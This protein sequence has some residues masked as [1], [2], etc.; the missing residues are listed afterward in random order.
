MT[1]TM[2]QKNYVKPELRKQL[3]FPKMLNDSTTPIKDIEDA[4]KIRNEEPGVRCSFNSFMTDTGHKAAL[5][6][7]EKRKKTKSKT[8]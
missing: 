1:K 7:L 3:V 2:T 4:V 5:E 6:L 8:A